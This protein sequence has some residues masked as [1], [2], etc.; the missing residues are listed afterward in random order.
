[1]GVS[2]IVVYFFSQGKKTK[3][4]KNGKHSREKKEE[5]KGIISWFLSLGLLRSFFFLPF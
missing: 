4:D 2:F 1:M 5:T 3:K